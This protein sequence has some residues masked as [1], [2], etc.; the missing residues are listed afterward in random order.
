MQWVTDGSGGL[1]LVLILSL[2]IA[3]RE[4]IWGS[5]LGQ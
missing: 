5:L 3:Q 4:D 1:Q 2:V